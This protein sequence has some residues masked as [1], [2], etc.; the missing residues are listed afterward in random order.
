[1]IK[2]TR[3]KLFKKNCTLF[4]SSPPSSLIQNIFAM[5]RSNLSICSLSISIDNKRSIVSI[6]LNRLCNTSFSNSSATTSSSSN[7]SSPKGTLAALTA[8]KPTNFLRY[9]VAQHLKSHTKEKPYKCSE[10]GDLVNFHTRELLKRHMNTHT[11]EKPYKC[12]FCEKDFTKNAHVSAHIR[13]EHTPIS[14]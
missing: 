2:Y 11:E 7:P 14:F 12:E 5:F 13:A 9:D 4:S 8:L 10:C 3:K 6:I 1:M